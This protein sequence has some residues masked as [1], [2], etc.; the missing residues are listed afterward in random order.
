MRE[1]V[2][3]AGLGAVSAAG[4]DVAST[5][6]S[7]RTGR[8]RPTRAPDL[9]FVLGVPVFAAPVPVAP[10]RSRTLALALRAAR[11]ALS[12]AGRI[13]GL[14]ARRIGVCMGTTV[15][16]QLN[17]VDFYA[18]FRASMP[19]AMEAVDRY[20]QGDLATVVARRLGF[21]GPRATVA[22]ACSSGTDAVGVA[23]DW[24]RGGEC[25]AALCG[26]A[27]ELSRIPM[28]GFHALGVMSPD[29][30]APFD[31]DRTGLNLGEGAGVLLL[32]SES[33]ARVLNAVP[34]LAV[35]GYGAA[36][37]A[38]HLT[39]PRP[40]GSGLEGAVR[41]ALADAG[42]GSDAAGFIN[43]HGT[44]TRE[45]DRIE[46]QTLGRIFGE[47]VRAVSTKGFTG[48]TLGAAGGLEAVFT[49]LGLREGWIPGCAGFRT[50]DPEIPFAPPAA[51]VAVMGRYAVSTSL[52]FGGGN[53]ALVLG[54]RGGGA[55]GGAP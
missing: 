20:L 51:P 3:I 44:A 40:D 24:I 2:L 37:D 30:C 6:E 47:G 10:G 22:N 31:R 29:A 43:A 21:K 18:A 49:A 52:A 19:P 34:D 46:G 15:A 45:N 8:V 25:D 48:H 9:G 35:T 55:A 12:A 7:F 50:R 38:Y 27:D 4:A 26:G 11:E 28:S 17:D 32:V 1:G 13:D 5:L 23:M 54:R 41:A 14:D 16:C 33:A 39:S 42:I 36:G 53:A